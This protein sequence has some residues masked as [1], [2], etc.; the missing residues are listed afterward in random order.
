MNSSV[1]S[2]LLSIQNI[3]NSLELSL[4]S[5]VKAQWD[6]SPGI[7]SRPCQHEEESLCLPSSVLIALLKRCVWDY[8]QQ[9]LLEGTESRISCPTL[10]KIRAGKGGRASAHTCFHACLCTPSHLPCR[11][12]DYGLEHF[13]RDLQVLVTSGSGVP[14]EGGFCGKY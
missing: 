14:V 9:R 4:K 10:C 8:A 5:R 11:K 3:T 7:Q 2:G 1:N 13:R 12:E 6:T